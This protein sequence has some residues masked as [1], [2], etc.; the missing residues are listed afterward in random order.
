MSITCQSP[1]YWF[2]IKVLQSYDNDFNSYKDDMIEWMRLYSLENPTTQ[3]SNL[4]GYQSPDDFYYEESFAP[5]MN[6][7]SEHILTTVDEYID[8]SMSALD[9]DQLSLCNMWFNINYENCYNVTH[10]H[11]GCILS[12]V[13][14]V[15]CPL[16][17]PIVFSCYD[18]FARARFEKYTNQSYTPQE[19]GL[20]LFPAHL[21]HRVDINPSKQ[22]RISIAFNLSE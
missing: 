20:M 22:P 4:G 14:W 19:G 1:D 8:D 7:I 18:E 2:P 16:P 5:Y 6:R 21:P 11:P 12:G 17:T 13:L 10:T 3:R 15:Q 9:K